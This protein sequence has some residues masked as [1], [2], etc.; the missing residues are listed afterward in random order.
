MGSYVVLFLN[1]DLEVV[2][3]TCYAVFILGNGVE[4]LT[5][6][7]CIVVSPVAILKGGLQKGFDL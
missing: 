5:R 3:V 6:G 1:Y 7:V 2:H 4:I